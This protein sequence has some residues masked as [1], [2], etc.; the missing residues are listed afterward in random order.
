MPCAKKGSFCF[1]VIKATLKIADDMDSYSR[2]KTILI[3]WGE[4]VLNL[5]YLELNV[6]LRMSW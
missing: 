4:N 3:E 2:R 6:T 1:H 5:R